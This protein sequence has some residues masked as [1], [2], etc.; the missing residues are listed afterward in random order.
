VYRDKFVEII[1]DLKLYRAEVGKYPLDGKIQKNY[2][3]IVLTREASDKYYII[4][5]KTMT[6]ELLI[7]FKK[8]TEQ[9]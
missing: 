4:I 7:T 5:N 6:R 1:I 3:C 8:L 2:D 9:S